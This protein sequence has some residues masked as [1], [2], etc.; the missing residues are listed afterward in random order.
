MV[1]VFVHPTASVEKG[2]SIG[3]GSKIWNYAHIREGAV[4]GENCNVGHC[5]FVDTEARI[6]DNVKIGNKVSIFKGVTIDSDAFIGPHVAFTNDKRPRS[7][8][9]WKLVKTCVKRGA[10]IGTNSTI[11]CGVTLG[12]GCMVGAGSVVTRDVPEH[13]LVYGNPARLRGFVC[14]CKG[15][16]IKKSEKKGFVTLR[17]VD[18]GREFRLGKSSYKLL[19]SG[20]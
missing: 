7:L 4:L 15:D 9:D 1:G 10:S 8:G 2:S 3:R 13:G 12:E 19:E 20:D 5:A 6:G 17:C 11:L 18:C 14:D 16:A